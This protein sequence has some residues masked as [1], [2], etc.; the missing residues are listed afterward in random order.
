MLLNNL[1]DK[2]L[3]SIRCYAI[4]DIIVEETKIF[5]TKERAP[6]YVCLELFKPHE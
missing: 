1:I 4:L 3:D 6:I 5:S 2:I